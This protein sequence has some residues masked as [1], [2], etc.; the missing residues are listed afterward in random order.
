M[1]TSNV[2]CCETHVTAAADFRTICFLYL[3]NF[4]SC[5]KTFKDFDISHRLW[6]NAFIQGTILYGLYSEK[7]EIV[8]TG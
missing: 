5:L 7:S 2:K 4:Q 3:V 6:C 8:T 1:E